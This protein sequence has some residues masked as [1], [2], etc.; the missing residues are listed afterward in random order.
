M[1]RS[2]YQ[3][4]LRDQ[5]GHRGV[6]S[7]GIVPQIQDIIQERTDGSRARPRDTSHCLRITMKRKILKPIVSPPSR[8]HFIPE[9]IGTLLQFISLLKKEGLWQQK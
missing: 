8:D 3:E 2:R 1:T 6:R 7:T 4:T 5:E 9:D